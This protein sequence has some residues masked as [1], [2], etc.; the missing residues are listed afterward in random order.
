MLKGNARL[1]H[2]YRLDW[3]EIR[4]IVQRGQE[5]LRRTASPEPV[6]AQWRSMIEKCKRHKRPID[7]GWLAR[8]L[9][10]RTAW[11]TGTRLIINSRGYLAE[12]MQSRDASS[13]WVAV[14]R[15]KYESEFRHDSRAILTA[16]GL[17]EVELS[18]ADDSVLLPV[19]LESRKP[20]TGFPG[21]KEAYLRSL[22]Q[23]TVTALTDCYVP[24]DDMG[25]QY[26]IEAALKA[27]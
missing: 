25:L 7:R 21:G 22:L 19:E 13:T 16:M 23:R 2:L 14:T 24:E 4:A 1:I 11:S 9:R 8:P 17:E 20:W 18:A 6:L 10:W 27:L 12:N 26:D 15:G 5:V 3:D